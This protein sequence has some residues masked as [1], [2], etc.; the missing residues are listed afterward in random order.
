MI[1]LTQEERVYRY[2]SVT[3]TITPLEAW[4]ALGVYRL[5][6]VIHKLRAQNLDIVNETAD[7][8][9]R[10]GEPCRVAKYR[11][12]KAGEQSCLFS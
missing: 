12:I 7:V 5:A 8:T 1:Q 3:P 4:S 2:L 10:F 6:A 9:N 11:L